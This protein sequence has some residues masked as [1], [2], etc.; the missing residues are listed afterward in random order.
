M[1][2]TKIYIGACIVAIA[3]VLFW[4]L[5]LPMYDGV[6]A[7]REALKERSAILDK[8]N[9]II[10]NINSLAKQYANQSAD[11]Q[12]FSAI[13]PP[14]KSVPELVSSIQALASQNGLT[15]TS[16]G[17]SGDTNQDKDLYHLQ[18]INIGLTGSYPAFR[19]FLAALE[20]NL[21]V[22]DIISID[23]SPTTE[24]SPIIGFR[25]KGNAYY[26]K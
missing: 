20:H 9:T 15:L 1:S 8:R 18:S 23:A 11:I 19:S 22:I 21:R 7:Q 3:G 25:I 26:I 13:V 5:L 6:A 10:A 12:R 16:L 4:V 24:N 17:L 2:S 14:Q